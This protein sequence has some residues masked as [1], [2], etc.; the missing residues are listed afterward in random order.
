MHVSPI[1]DRF[2]VNILKSLPEKK[3]NDQFLAKVN[4]TVSTL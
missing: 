1:D 3:P 2:S 4:I